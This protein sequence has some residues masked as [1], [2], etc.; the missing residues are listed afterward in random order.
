MLQ[1]IPIRTTFLLAVLGFDEYLN[2][3]VGEVQ[4]KD[5]N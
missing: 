3:D 1:I 4:A 5:L 2:R